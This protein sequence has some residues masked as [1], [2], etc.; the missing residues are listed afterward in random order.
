MVKHATAATGSTVSGK[1]AAP[2]WN[3]DHLSIPFEVCLLTTANVALAGTASA[4]AGTEMW[5]TSK[6]TRNRIDLSVASQFRLVVTVTAL[7]SATTAGVKVQY[8]TTNAAT[9][10]GT[11]IGATTNSLVVGSGTAGTVFDLGWQT[12]AA[13]AQVD[14]LY[15]ALAVSVAF[16]TTAPSFGGASVFFK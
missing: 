1:I 14:N 11:D 2:E 9:W 8:M 4:T 16:G 10:A 6:P 13:G 5:T 3:A 12:L 15:I 7:G